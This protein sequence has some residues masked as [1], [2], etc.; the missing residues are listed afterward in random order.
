MDD[1]WVKLIS[2][3][4]VVI[5]VYFCLCNVSTW[6]KCVELLTNWQGSLFNYWPPADGAV[7]STADLLLGIYWQGSLINCPPADGAVDS[8][9]DL[10]TQVGDCR[11]VDSTADLHRVIYW[12]GSW[13]NCSPADGAVDSTTDF[14]T[15]VSD[16]ADELYNS[17]F[18]CRKR[19][20]R[21]PIIIGRLS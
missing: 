9:A 19:N 20:E 11:A 7:D 12:H 17:S 1:C 6:F 14:L 2:R 8:T 15:Q 3:L 21:V 10:L 13:I 5:L 4:W 18:T 16:L